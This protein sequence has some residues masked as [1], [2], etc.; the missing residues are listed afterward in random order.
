MQHFTIKLCAVSLALPMLAAC[1]HKDLCFDH[2]E[3]AVRYQTRVIAEH[4]LQWEIPHENNTD[5]L[6]N[7]DHELHGRHYHE[8]IPG[9]PEGIRVAVY[10]PEPPHYVTNL[11]NTGGVVD[12]RPGV[13]SLIFYNNDTEYIQFDEMDEYASAK[14]STRVRSRASYKGNPLA[15]DYGTRAEETV[16]PADALFAH[17]I[18]EHEQRPV[19]SPQELNITLHPLVFTYVIRFEFESGQEYIGI[20]RGALSDMARSVSLSNG[21][22]STDKATILFDCEVKPWGVEALVGSFGVPDFP[23]PNYTRG[24]YEHGLN[25]EVRLKNG[26]TFNFNHDVTDQI[27]K[28]PTGGVIRVSGLKIS[29][30]DGLEGGGG[31]DVTVEGWGEDEDIDIVIKPKK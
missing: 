27:E 17:Y 13:N 10:H 6:N 14:A 19:T 21:R 18:D 4:N 2:P 12:M 15:S 25:L 8:L 31:F 24:G 5:W 26:K 22:T 11:P 3:H 23:N 1:D 30:D 28:Q 29:E 16:A 7:W 9:L 20:A